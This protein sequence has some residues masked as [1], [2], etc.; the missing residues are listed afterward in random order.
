MNMKTIWLAYI[1][2]GEAAKLTSQVPTE[3]FELEPLCNQISQTYLILLIH[4]ISDKRPC[5]P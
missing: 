4:Q 5:E 1:L 3:Y 2:I